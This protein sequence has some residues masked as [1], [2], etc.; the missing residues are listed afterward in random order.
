MPSS[1]TYPRWLLFSGLVAVSGVI[2]YLH[3]SYYLPFFSDDALISLRYTERLL[4]GK[5][6]TWTDG[7]AVEGYSNFLWVLLTALP[8]LLGINLV[9]GARVLAFVCMIG[10]VAALYRRYPLDTPGNTQPLLFGASALLLSGPIAVW[11][12]GGM[13]QGLVACCLSLSL[14]ALLPYVDPDGHARRSVVA[15]GIPLALLTL[16][17]PDGALFTALACASI[18]FANRLD[19]AAW[20]DAFRLAAIPAAAYLC[21]LA[22]RLLYYGEWV[23]N[24]A[25]VKVTPS[26]EHIAG[27]LHYIGAGLWAARPVSLIAFGA[28]LLML[29]D[30]AFRGRALLLLVM[31][32]GWAGYIA[33]VGGD[34]F[35]AW[36]HHVPLIVVMAYLFAL[37]GE[38]M[39]QP[40]RANRGRWVPCLLLIASITVYGYAQFS[41]PRTQDA[42]SEMW[43]WDGKVTGLVLRR[44]FGDTQ[45]LLA[46]DAAGCVPFWS[47]LPCIDMLGLNDHHIARHRHENVGWGDI[48]HE[49][50]DG[51]YVMARKPDLVLFNRPDEQPWALWKSGAEMQDMPEFFDQYAAVIFEGDDPHVHRSLIWVRR[52]SVRVGIRESNEQI[53]VPPYLLTNTGTT[54]THLDANNRFVTDTSQRQSK[55][56]ALDLPPGTWRL[57]VDTPGDVAAT[58]RRPG[59]D[60]LLADDM[61]PLTFKLTGDAM[62]RIELTL[63]PAKRERIQIGNI[64]L[65]NQKISTED[66]YR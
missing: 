5:G 22:F 63:R 48:G 3:A 55:S 64:V 27:G 19:R 26:R 66:G 57:R 23:P 59:E 53:I 60:S 58:A 29:C 17:R 10:T 2:L 44:G 24:T 7:K 12:I 46:V 41:D 51:A 34:I 31:A 30:R 35:P 13:E 1:Y 45:P 36:R 47:R 25:L 14:S 16:T 15:A 65:T 52:Q 9:T 11:A 20:K 6:L 33:F 61:L 21:L 40:G 39:A 62:T 56:I 49:F 28:G 32:A 18:V 50:G 4:D 38:Y 37:V 54:V 43:E 8:G 42:R